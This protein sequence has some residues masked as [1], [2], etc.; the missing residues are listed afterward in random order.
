MLGENV[1]GVFV[2]EGPGDDAALRQATTAQRVGQLLD[3][4]AVQ[5]GPVQ[6]LGEQHLA[7]LGDDFG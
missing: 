5:Q 6:F 3:A 4:V 7:Q 1:C 2:F